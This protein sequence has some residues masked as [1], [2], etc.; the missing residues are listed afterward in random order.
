[1]TL[2]KQITL[3]I[4]NA[5]SCGIFEVIIGNNNPT[6]QNLTDVLNFSSVTIPYICLFCIF[7]TKLET[8]CPFPLFIMD[9][10]SIHSFYFV[11]LPF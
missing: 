9:K 1:M 2:V 10:S 4:A 3:K 8:F 7:L 11:T 5:N 6:I